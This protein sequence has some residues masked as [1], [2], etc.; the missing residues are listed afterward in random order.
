MQGM[1]QP[2]PFPEKFHLA[3]EFSGVSGSRIT[4]P[5]EGVSL[6]D[7][8]RLLLYALHQQATEGQCQ[9]AKPW[10]WNVVERAKWTS[11]KQLGSMSNVE[12]M[13]LFVRTLE[14][15]VPNWFALSLAQQGGATASSNGTA[16]NAAAASTP[17]ASSS[18]SNNP[19]GG[20]VASGDAAPSGARALASATDTSA[21][22][23]VADG[24]A[25]V[26]VADLDLAWDAWTPVPTRGRLP[27][28]RYQHA[29]A[30][31][32]DSMYIIAGNCG[33]RY[34][35]DVQ[36][37]DLKTLTW[38]RPEIGGSTAS[39]PLPPVSSPPVSLPPPPHNPL[40]PC[41]G[42]SVAVWGKSILAVGGHSK[43]ASPTMT[44]RA[45]D[46]VA[47]EWHMLK[48]SGTPP[49]A[50]GG[51]SMVLIGSRLFVLGGE[52]KGR[53][54]LADLHVLDLE[55]M[56][57]D[58]PEVKG[59]GP[60]PRSD[61]L[62]TAYGSRY[63]LVFGG[64]SH[65][66]CFNDLHLLDILT[67]SWLTPVCKGPPP[68]P[69]AGH[70]GA[71]IGDCWFITG[72]GDN[73]QG[74]VDTICLDMASLTWSLVTETPQR[75]A[76]SS[77]GLS[78]VLYK[79]ADKGGEK[80]TLITFGGYNGRYC[81]EVNVFRPQSPAKAPPVMVE[82]RAAAQAA[83][84]AAAVATAEAAK[85]AAKVAAKAASRPVAPAKEEIEAAA[86]GDSSQKGGSLKSPASKAPVQ[87]TARQPE[88]T[89][90]HS[91]T[92]QGS[93]K[94]SSGSSGG[95]SGSSHGHDRTAA[96]PPAPAPVDTANLKRIAA[97]TQELDAALAK[98][99][100]AEE[101][102]EAA[103]SGLRALQTK[104]DG[105]ARELGQARRELQAAREQAADAEQE[106]AAARSAV[107]EEQSRCFHLEVENAELR[108][109]LL[110]MEAL[111]KEL[112]L[113]RLRAA[114]QEQKAAEMSK[115]SAGVWGW[116]SGAPSESS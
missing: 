25:C 107:A 75:S 56:T 48:P 90:G 40:L 85:E 30:V 108:Q 37:L 43:D 71:V 27:P 95:T 15:E 59:V 6:G 105:L 28:S 42:L 93:H 55:T 17:I 2:P 23:L 80:S 14:E 63:M 111:E 101:K 77:E 51:H 112:A 61:H 3:A 57:W 22:R 88:H 110:G 26:G 34:L 81:N 8:T 7:E 96:E 47:M 49:C 65:T 20:A 102:T 4:G 29:A 45:L 114:E 91:N 92:G 79:S 62:A 97:L 109:K 21:G 94:N 116:I 74:V 38:S 113:L 5:P 82:S 54:L 89:N 104:A 70:A 1:A 19:S 31:L 68:R 46:T 18:N 24:Q 103:Q 16:P 33:G 99:R 66:F 58:S 52:S 73:A 60:S 78:M 39:S 13:R 32:G 69:R 72:G 84:Q 87:A 35:S 53:R 106:L 11:W 100:A 10:G 9:H 98:C 64:G 115:K 12:A 36:V 76:L 44:V 67:M 50:R 86:N 41:A 83:E